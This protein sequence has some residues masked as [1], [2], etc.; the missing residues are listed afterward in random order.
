MIAK[1]IFP[2]KPH[3]EF[4]YLL[5]KGIQFSR[6]DIIVAPLRGRTE[7]G[8]IIDI[9]TKTNISND[10]IKRIYGKIWDDVRIPLSVVNLCIDSS[11]YFLYS[12]GQFLSI[13]FPVKTLGGKKKFVIIKDEGLEYLKNQIPFSNTLFAQSIL[14]RMFGKKKIEEWYKNKW[15]DIKEMKLPIPSFNWEK[16]KEGEIRSL[17]ILKPNKPFISANIKQSFILTEEQDIAYKRVKDSVDKNIYDTFLLYGVTGSGKTE[18]YLRWTEYVLSKGKNAL[19]LVPEIIL[20]EQIVKSFESYFSDSVALIHSRLTDKERFDMYREIAEGK[21]KV[22]IGVRSAIFAPIENLG[23]IIIDE[24]HSEN[25]IQKDMSPRYNAINIANMRAKKEKCIIV[26]GSATPSAESFYAVDKGTMKLLEL[27]ERIGKSGHP[28][29]VIVRPYKNINDE[30]LDAIK[31]RIEKKEQTILLYNRRG[32]ARVNKCDNCGYVQECKNCSLPLVYHKTDNKVKCHYCNYTIALE[33]KCPICG[34]KMQIYGTGTQKIEETVKERI[35]YAKIARLDIDTTRNRKETLS[36]L[37]DFKEGKI[38]ILIG[39]QIVTKGFDIENVTL[40]GI[41]NSDILLL[42]PDF[43]SEEHFIQMLYQTAGRSGRGGKKGEVIIESSNGD[44]I[45]K[46]L[47]GYKYHEHIKKILNNRHK[48]EYPPYIYMHKVSWSFADKNQI[49]NLE[50]KIDPYIKIL[51]K[52]ADVQILGPVPDFIEK[53]GGFYKIQLIVKGK[54]IQ[55]TIKVIKFI[56]DKFGGY[57]YIDAL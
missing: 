13:A 44:Y 20:A 50:K 17:P 28:R 2:I 9:K 6:G 51:E 5:P 53:I 31:E 36:I 7:V 19:I 15:I 30:I 42:L 37:Q 34:Q 52:E 40:V 57:P 24:E 54:K 26:R 21:R 1:I 47:R 8:V 55:N 41:I 29:F 12:A 3:R 32:Y 23:I 48:W 49:Y 45:E 22:I 38:D 56:I 39:T 4:D 10:K 35:P 46:I 18:L 16:Q 33:E 14:V 11:K 43:R 25:Y 27:K